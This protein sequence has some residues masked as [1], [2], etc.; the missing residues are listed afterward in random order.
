MSTLAQRVRAGI[1]RAHSF[2]TRDI[3]HIGAPGEK[4]PRGFI[5]K[6]LRV[7]ILLG[8]KLI[9][10]QHMMRA[11]SLTF[12]TLLS[13]VPLLAVTFFIIS[14]LSLDKDVYQFISSKIE[15]AADY[16]AGEEE[17]TPIPAPAD[18][19]PPDAAPEEAAPT[20]APPAS[21][22]AGQDE[23]ITPERRTELQTEIIE[24]LF[25]GVTSEREGMK[26]P[27]E[28][29][30]ST[31]ENL[32][33]LANDAASNSAALTIS[34]ALLVITTVFG[35]MRNIENTFNRI[36]GV[37]RR[38]SLYRT[39]ADYFI[40]MLLAPFVVTAA[41]GVLTAMESE[42]VSRAVGPFR[43]VLG[44]GQ[45]ALI[46]V[47][48]SVLYRFVPNTKVMFR[49]A[50]LAGLIAG[51][52]W[53]GLS[54]GY[55]RF[56]FGLARYALILSAF[57]QFPLLLMWVYLS[58]AIVLLGCEVAYAYQHERTYALERY[59]SGA[60]FAYREAVGLRA[61]IEIGY[62]FSEGKPAFNAE[63]VSQE[64]NVP[65]RLLDGVLDALVATGLL[66]VRA[67]EQE[68][69]LPGKPL[70][71]INAS[72]IIRVLRNDGTEPSRFLHDSRFRNMYTELARVDHAFAGATLA[73][74]VA[75]H[76][77]TL[78]GDPTTVPAPFNFN[79]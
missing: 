67:G 6:Q 21:A 41:M 47:V 11:A 52:L 59:A 72:D 43:V 38:R 13:I 5:I 19:V 29:I 31:A 20:E 16:V 55:V 4:L 23:E 40:I 60:S 26:D 32:A 62:R 64:W 27:V 46:V 66:A 51:T 18:T 36:W 61:M 56:Q 22:V 17:T 30:S 50:V 57:A 8:S 74:L 71:R 7:A 15:H 3:W 53:L 9:D 76:T 68:E 44:L 75:G 33:K 1:A 42:S 10:G 37:R 70:D 28:G 65:L 24:K 49:Y 77:A 14:K 34:G 54:W 39:F 45:Y 73:E 12:A 48:F 69:Y 35:L 2:A 63:V 78:A 79:A 25:R 58:W